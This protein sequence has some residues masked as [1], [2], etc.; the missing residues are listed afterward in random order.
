EALAITRSLGSAHATGRQGVSLSRAHGHVLAVDL[1][2]DIAQPP[3][4]NSAMDG[5]ALRHADL[6]AEGSTRLRLVGEQFAG[7]AQP[8]EVGPGECIRI[9]TGA[10]MPRGA[11]TV[12]INEDTRA[13]GGLVDVLSAPGPG[14]HVR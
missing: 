2:A 9:T 8:R 14:R 6:A 4:D 13:E 11:D 12:V 5:Y 7:R 10:P 1:V 3:F